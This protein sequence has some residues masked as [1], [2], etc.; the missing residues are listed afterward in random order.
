MP[1][2][3]LAELAQLLPAE[4]ASFAAPIPTRFV[5]SDEFM[6]LPQTVRQREVVRSSR[7]ARCPS[8]G[9]APR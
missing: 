2:L 3:D 4:T 9:C 7:R 5:S 6:P 1:S 8:P